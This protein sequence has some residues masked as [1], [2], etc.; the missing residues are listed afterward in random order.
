[1]LSFFLA[2]TCGSASP[3]LSDSWGS[4][5]ESFV[6]G[7]LLPP[8]GAAFS[9]NFRSHIAGVNPL[10]APAA[11]FRTVIN[12]VNNGNNNNSGASMNGSD[13]NNALITNADGVMTNINSFD[14]VDTK[15][16][17]QAAALAGYSGMSGESGKNITDI[18]LDSYGTSTYDLI[19]S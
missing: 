13:N 9:V 6:G 12:G 16:V 18:P 11:N 8:T 17:I 4:S 10:V 14:G 15:P 3:T 19:S 1:M 2:V 5:S 7:G